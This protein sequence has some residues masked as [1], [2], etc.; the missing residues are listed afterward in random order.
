MEMGRRASTGDFVPEA[1][2]TVTMGPERRGSGLFAP[3]ERRG[4]PPLCEGFDVIVLG[5]ARDQPLA[6]APEGAEV[7]SYALF[8]SI[9]AS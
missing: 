6:S 3:R 9:V 4:Y 8:R 2:S 1:P 7:S 5:G